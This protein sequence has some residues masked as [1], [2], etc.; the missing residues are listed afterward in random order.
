MKIGDVTL[1][2]IKDY[3]R[4]DYDDDD[5]QI[6]TIMLAA[7]AYIRGY[8]GLDNLTMDTKEDLTIA[9]KVLCND[10]YANKQYMVQNDKVNVV[11]KS[12][13]DM[14]SINLL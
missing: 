1:Q 11:I 8:T 14:H 2:D 12:I 10:M 13:L 3:A 5:M 6:E 4:I 7:K 9:F